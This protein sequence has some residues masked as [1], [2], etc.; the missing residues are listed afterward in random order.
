MNLRPCSQ[1]DDKSSAVRVK[2]VSVF[3]QEAELRVAD[4]VKD[5]LLRLSKG[6]LFLAKT[7]ILGAFMVG[8]QLLCALETTWAVCLR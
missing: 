4:Y 1:C 2:G 7:G 3:L 6:F 5:G 8:P